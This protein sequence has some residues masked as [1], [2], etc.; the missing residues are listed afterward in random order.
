MHENVLQD[1]IL[2]FVAYNHAYVLI[3]LSHFT[4]GAMRWTWVENSLAGCSPEEASSRKQHR[5]VWQLSWD[6][7]RHLRFTG[8]Q[9]IWNQRDVFQCPLVVDAGVLHLKPGGG[10]SI[11]NWAT[12]RCSKHKSAGLPTNLQR[13]RCNTHV[14]PGRQ[15]CCSVADPGCR[16]LPG[17]IWASLRCWARAANSALPPG[18]CHP[19]RD[20]TGC[21]WTPQHP[22]RCSA[23]RQEI[24]PFQVKTD[25]EFSVAMVTHLVNRW[26]KD[27]GFTKFAGKRSVNSFFHVVLKRWLVVGRWFIYSR[28]QYRSK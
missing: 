13:I 19:R 27:L 10:P 4:L 18:P 3:P 9:E 11:N 15:W 6:R 5:R 20:P 22:G 26:G 8:I 1:I 16:P 23:S 7:E 12:D 24:C 21:C 2:L 28:T 17:W 25:A 14:A